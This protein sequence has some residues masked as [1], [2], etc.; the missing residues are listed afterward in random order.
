MAAMEACPSVG[1]GSSGFPPGKAYEDFAVIVSF[2]AG[3]GRTSCTTAST[4]A[5]SSTIGA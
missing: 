1:Q 2:G 5:R 4:T 3:S